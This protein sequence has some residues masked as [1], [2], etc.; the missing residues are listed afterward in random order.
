MEKKEEKLM[1]SF[2]PWYKRIFCKHETKPIGNLRVYENGCSRP[3]REYVR[4]I[5]IKCGKIKKYKM[6]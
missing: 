1:V 3:Y 4:F 5:C 6:V 2:K